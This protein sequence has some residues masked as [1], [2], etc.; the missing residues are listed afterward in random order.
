MPLR[1][2][3]P[4]GSAMDIFCQAKPH[5]VIEAF[6]V[7]CL[8]EVVEAL[9]LFKRDESATIDI[10]KNSIPMFSRINKSGALSTP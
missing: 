6:Y 4:P 1:V 10:D 5:V 8:I 3:L 7:I 2:T 9:K